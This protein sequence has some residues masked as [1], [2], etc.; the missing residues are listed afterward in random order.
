MS[1]PFA[2]K[3]K[4]LLGYHRQLAP[5]AAVRVSPLCL[6]GMSF[7]TAW[8]EM[9]GSCD[10]TTTFAI[11]DYFKSQGGNFIDTA[12]NYQDEQSE[13]WIGEWMAVRGCRD[14]MVIATKFTTAYRAYQGYDG[15]VQSNFGGNNAKG[16]RHSV[17]ASLAKLGTG[18]IDLLWLHW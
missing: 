3:P 15:L 5:S 2:P 10:K 17:E 1:F 12:S 11:L 18:Y 14:E 6:G 13:R 7:G 16:M 8:Q 9:L 4:S